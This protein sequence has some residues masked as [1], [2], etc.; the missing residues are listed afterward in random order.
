MPLLQDSIDSNVIPP[1]PDTAHSETRSAPVVEDTTFGT[2]EL[3]LDELLQLDSEPKPWW[4]TPIET[5]LQS[6]DQ[7]DPSLL[8]QDWPSDSMVEISGTMPMAATTT[9]LTQEKP[10]P[11]SHSSQPEPA[12]ESFLPELC[13]SCLAI[14]VSKVNVSQV[15]VFLQTRL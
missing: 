15:P 9:Q 3:G 11:G 6:L 1:H 13:V 10:S 12:L 5:L 4:N 14:E 7:V 2:M 8:T